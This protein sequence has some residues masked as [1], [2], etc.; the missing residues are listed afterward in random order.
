MT[1]RKYAYIMAIAQSGNLSKAAITLGVSQP[2][3][4]QFL[5]KE[6]A[7]VGSKI[8]QKIDNQMVLTYAGECYVK[9][10]Q[11]ILSLQNEMLTTMADIA[12]SEKGRIRIGVPA[13]RRPYTILSVIP[14]FRRKYPD[15]EIEL[16]ENNS[17]ILEKMLEEMKL[18]VIAVDVMKSNDN[19]IYQ[20]IAEE[21]IVLAVYAD[22][23]LIQQA[24]KT[25]GCRYPALHPEV[26]QKENFILLPA[27]S[28]SREFMEKILISGK[29]E[30]QT[31]M[32]AKTIDSALEAVSVNLGITFTPEI[33][34]SYIRNYKN[35]RYLSVISPHTRYEFDILFR[36]NAYISPALKEFADLFITNYQKEKSCFY[37]E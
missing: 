9:Y 27:G 8:F 19:F 26:L 11:K 18:D 31:S 10:T 33:P 7:L 21:E 16:T 23:P 13:I 36:K 14:A 37:E 22:S 20:K 6:E 2:A 25:E 28:R 35:I 17:S 15:I 30:I 29:I 4:S 24:V 32:T 3:L 1:D 5:Q 34:L 12:K